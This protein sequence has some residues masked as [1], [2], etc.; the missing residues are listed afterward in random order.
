[1]DCSLP[2]SSVHGIFQARI[3]E[4]VAISYSRGPFKPRDWTH[5]SCV[6][7]I[8]RRIL[9]HCA[10]WQAPFWPLC[11]CYSHF[12]HTHDVQQHRASSLHIRPQ[13]ALEHFFSPLVR[14]FDPCS[15]D[16]QLSLVGSLNLFF[17]SIFSVLLFTAIHRFMVTIMDDISLLS[18]DHYTWS[19]FSSNP[20]FNV[21]GLR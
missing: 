10:T 17:C 13:E 11:T 21:P 1:M 2:G 9:Y 7:Y 15:K 12:L 16:W 5:F 8:G 14:L 18:K 3:L 20:A 19:T 6:S 4:W